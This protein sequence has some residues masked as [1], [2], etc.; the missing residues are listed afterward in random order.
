MS[1]IPCYHAIASIY[2]NNGDPYKELDKCYSKELFLRI[3]NNVLEPINGQDH[4]PLSSMLVLDP[5]L[6]VTQL[7]RP[8]KARK[9]DVTKVKI[10][11]EN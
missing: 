4:W 6:S 10:M 9:R 7:E 11:E 5:P 2:M 3:Y 8:K 1:G